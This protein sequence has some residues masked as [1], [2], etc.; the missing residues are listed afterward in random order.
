[1]GSVSPGEP[2]PRFTE[3]VQRAL[4][5]TDPTALAAVGE[6]DRR[7]VRGPAARVPPLPR[8]DARCS[9]PAWLREGVGGRAKT[10]RAWR[11]PSGWRVCDL[12]PVHDTNGVGT[13]TQAGR[14]TPRCRAEAFAHP[15]RG[16]TTSRRFCFPTP[17]RSVT[18]PCAVVRQ[19]ANGSDSPSAQ[20][21]RGLRDTGTPVTSH[22]SRSPSAQGRWG[23]FHQGN[24]LHDSQS[25][26]SERCVQQTPLPLRRLV[27]QIGG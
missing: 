19:V 20:G 6:S 17:F 10:T 5:P 11:Q 7:L 3:C 16:V 4:C 18:L 12:D 15:P 8:N 9:E 25:A 23:R 21:R 14:P 22:R 2:T 26:C 24:R 13:H 27:N 1:M